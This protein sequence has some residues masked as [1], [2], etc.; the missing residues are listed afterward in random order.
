LS[1]A[2]AQMISTTPKG[3]YRQGSRRHST[4]DNHRRTKHIAAPRRPNAYI[5]T[6]MSRRARQRRPAQA[7]FDVRT[8]EPTTAYAGLCESGIGETG[9]KSLDRA[10]PAAIHITL[11][12]RIPVEATVGNLVDA[13]LPGLRG[14]ALADGDKDEAGFAASSSLTRTAPYCPAGGHAELHTATEASS[15]MAFLFAAPQ[16]LEWH[17]VA[18]DLCDQ[19]LDRGS[20]RPRAAS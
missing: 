15:I 9:A 8:H 3:K 10:E 19:R 20:R 7:Q 13:R 5:T 1:A 4:R 17:A 12:S 6:M 11:V 14:T 16:L 2:L 18:L